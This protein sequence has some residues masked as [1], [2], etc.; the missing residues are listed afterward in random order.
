MQRLF[1]VYYEFSVSIEKNSIGDRYSND[2]FCNYF[3]E[4]KQCKLK[5]YCERI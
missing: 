5:K 4:L 1:Y 2:Y 3:I